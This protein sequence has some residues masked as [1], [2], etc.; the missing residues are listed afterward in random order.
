[1]ANL[2]DELKSTLKE[3]IGTKFSNPKAKAYMAII[4]N[5]GEAQVFLASG[6]E[7]STHMGDRGMVTDDTLIYVDR[8]GQY[9]VLFWDQVETV[10]FHLG[11]KE[12]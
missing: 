3:V 1:M 5:H 11:Y 8:F 6:A 9:N 4:E 10:N 12:A 2:K 7:H